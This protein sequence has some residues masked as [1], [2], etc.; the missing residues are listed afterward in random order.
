M[1]SISKSR[2][3]MVLLRFG[4]LIFNVINVQRHI[5]VFM[6]GLRLIHIC[7]NL[8]DNNRGEIN[9][10]CLGYDSVMRPYLQSSLQSI[11]IF[12]IG[13]YGSSF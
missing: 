6:F 13:F 10:K 2:R 8:I 1:Q 9:K 12:M 7:G 3:L 11:D 5:V 4:H